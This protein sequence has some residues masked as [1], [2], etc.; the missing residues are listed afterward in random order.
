MEIKDLRTGICLPSQ[1]VDQSTT[2]KVVTC[3]L[4]HSHGQPTVTRSVTVNDDLTWHV[5]IHGQTLNT[6]KCVALKCLPVTVKTKIALNR[7]LKLVDSLNICAGH[8]EDHILLTLAKANFSQQVT[9]QWLSLIRTTLFISMEMSTLVQFVPVLVSF[10][11]MDQN[12][13]F[14]RSIDLHFAHYIVSG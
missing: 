3:K 13:T 11:S 9:A 12:V 14:E 2:N 4:Q 6:S 7:L 5:R 1:W 10:W 8:P